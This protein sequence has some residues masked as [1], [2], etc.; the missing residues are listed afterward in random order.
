MSTRF[1]QAVLLLIA[2][3]AFGGLACDF[4]FNLGQASKPQITLQAPASGIGEARDVGRDLIR[5]DNKGDAG[6]AGDAVDHTGCSALQTRLHVFTVLSG[7]E[8]DGLAIGWKSGG[9]GNKDEA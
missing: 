1:V 7:R 9:P 4:S 8:P 5:P 6:F 3:A 2:L